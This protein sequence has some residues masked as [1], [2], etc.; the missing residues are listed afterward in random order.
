M[1]KDGKSPLLTQNRQFRYSSSREVRIYPILPATAATLLSQAGHEV[2]YLDGINEQLSIGQ[3]MRRLSDFAPELAMLET[4]A[5]L[6]GRHSEIVGQMKDEAGCKVAVVGD[7]V[8]WRPEEALRSTGADYAIASGD[9]DWAFYQLGELLNSGDR[10][11]SGT[12]GQPE[13]GDRGCPALDDLDQLPFIDRKLTKWWLYGEAYLNHPCTYIMT[14]R[15]CGGGP[16]GPGACSFCAWQHLLWHGRPRLRSAG[17]VASELD[18]LLQGMHLSEVFDDNESGAIWNARWLEAFLHEMKDRGILGEVTI[19]SNARA[20]SLT[21]DTCQLLR[22]LGYRL[23]KV[24]VES[25]NDETLARIG[26]GETIDEIRRGIRNAKDAGLTVMMTVM[27][28]YPWE[29]PAETER[30]LEFCRDLMRYKPKMGD[31]LQASVIVPYPGTPIYT[32]AV[33]QGWL[34]VNPQDYEMY[35]MSRPVLESKVDAFQKQII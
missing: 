34:A 35:D 5:P 7:H 11:P 33:E 12:W 29:G 14:G 22:K 20:D 15:G 10:V 21:K 1:S 16:R 4:K 8:C 27:V 2:L 23:L 9:Y 32:Q 13:H 31:S 25:G 17:N 6:L 26:K 28:G 18:L 24:G 3:F 19:S 30:T